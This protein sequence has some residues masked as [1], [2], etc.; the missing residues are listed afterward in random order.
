MEMS[1]SLS[2]LMYLEVHAL[3]D[4]KKSSRVKVFQH[5]VYIFAAFFKFHFALLA[6]LYVEFLFQFHFRFC[7]AWK[8]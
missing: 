7:A 4:K 8:L 1:H 5:F 3:R 6:A 2:S